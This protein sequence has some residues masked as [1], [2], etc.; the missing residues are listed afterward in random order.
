MPA[1]LSEHAAPPAPPVARRLGIALSD[2]FNIAVLAVLVVIGVALGAFALMLP[3]ALL[4]YAAGVARTYLDP[5]TRERA[6]GGDGHGRA[7]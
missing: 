1:R 7:S 6:A 3:L 4:V 5:A 2:P